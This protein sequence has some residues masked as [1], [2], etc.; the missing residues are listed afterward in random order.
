M[1]RTTHSVDVDQH[2]SLLTLGSAQWAQE[3]DGHSRKDGYAWAQQHGRPMR[4]QTSDGPSVPQ[5][6]Q[7][8]QPAAS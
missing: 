8:T 4:A 3:Q 1:E 6:P 7:G 2:R 5:I